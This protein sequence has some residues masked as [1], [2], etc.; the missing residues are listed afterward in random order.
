MR[1][2]NATRFDKQ[3]GISFFIKVFDLLLKFN[4]SKGINNDHIVDIAGNCDV[5]IFVS[6]SS[7][8]KTARILLIELVIWL[9]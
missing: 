4:L 7:P 9:R 5:L 8:I 6:E 1:V 3:R 2:L